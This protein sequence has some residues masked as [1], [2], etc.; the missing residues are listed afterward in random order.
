MFTSQMQGLAEVISG[1]LFG[2][3]LAHVLTDEGGKPFAFGGEALHLSDIPATRAGMGVTVSIPAFKP[4]QNRVVADFVGHDAGVAVNVL[5]SF[6][7]GVR[8]RMDP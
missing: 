3:S 4:H 6:H 1:K 2:V 8:F 5:V 7:R